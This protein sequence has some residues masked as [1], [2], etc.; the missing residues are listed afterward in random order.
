MIETGRWHRPHSIPYEER[1]CIVCDT[2]E[3]ESHFILECSRYA[4]IRKK[5]INRY[6]WSRPNVLKFN[7]LMT[8]SNPRIVKNLASF[9]FEGFQIRYE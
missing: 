4:D 3:D 7:E 5:F 9:V 1:K 2:I 8:S 6:Y